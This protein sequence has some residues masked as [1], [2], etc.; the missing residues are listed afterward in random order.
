M[1]PKGSSERPARGGSAANRLNGEKSCQSNDKGGGAKN[2][3]A[4]G[5]V[6]KREREREV[7]SKH[8]STPR[9]LKAPRNRQKHL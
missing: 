6:E 3:A 9:A 4:H 7:N 1:V 8:Q 2:N 5:K